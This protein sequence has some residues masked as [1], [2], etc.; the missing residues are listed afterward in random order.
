MFQV[1][2]AHLKTIY[3]VTLEE[4]KQEA[5][6]I[7]LETPPQYYRKR[8][9]ERSCHS[10]ENLLWTEFDSWYRSTDIVLDPRS[11]KTKVLALHK[12]EPVIDI[13]MYQV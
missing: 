7:A 13:G 11:L 3:R 12:T 10:D 5:L 6:V 2:F 4:E 1:P 8:N 9:D